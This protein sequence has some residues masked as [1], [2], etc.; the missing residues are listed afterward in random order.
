MIGLTFRHLPKYSSK[1]FSNLNFSSKF[2]LNSLTYFNFSTTK[3]EEK[4]HI[5]PAMK[6][7]MENLDNNIIRR[8]YYISVLNF[9]KERSLN[10][11]E[12]GQMQTLFM[13]YFELAINKNIIIP[14]VL[15]EAARLEINSF[16]FWKNLNEL[17]NKN[18]HKMGPNIIFEFFQSF[19][20]AFPNNSNV[21][22]LKNIYFSNLTR[23]KVV[24]FNLETNSIC[25]DAN[26][27]ATAFVILLLTSVPTLRLAS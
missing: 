7:I 23:D 21:V 27:S 5:D 25:D 3:I 19:D 22:L 10:V 16:A 11:S 8:E 14:R 20:D 26:F 17:F 9:F 6:K 13:K 1:I 24:S 15:N 18:F 12:R 2:K 4:L